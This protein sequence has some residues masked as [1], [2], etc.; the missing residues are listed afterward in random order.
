MHILDCPV[1]PPQL[2]AKLLTVKGVADYVEDDKIECIFFN[3]P[4]GILTAEK[5]KAIALSCSF[6]ASAVNVIMSDKPFAH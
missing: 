4:Q 1:L 6:P 5:V 2:K 3:C